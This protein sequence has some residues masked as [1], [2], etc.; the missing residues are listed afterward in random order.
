[1]PATVPGYS[2]CALSTDQPAQR[3]DQAGV[4]ARAYF[5]E[6]TPQEAIDIATK[7]L[8]DGDFPK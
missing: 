7:W 8:G 5:E 6:G 1:M 3:A 2:R 4:A